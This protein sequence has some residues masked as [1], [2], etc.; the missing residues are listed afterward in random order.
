MDEL[1]VGL[2]IP[3]LRV[4]Y[5]RLRP[6][7]DVLS[8]TPPHAIGVAFTPQSAAVWDVGTSCR[9]RAAIPTSAVFITSSEPLL[10]ARRD[11]LRLDDVRPATARDH[12]VRLRVNGPERTVF[13]DVRSSLLDTR[14]AARMRSRPFRSR[15]ASFDLAVGSRVRQEGSAMRVRRE[16][17]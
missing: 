7:E 12:D 6:G 3:G 15:P 16:A 10:W 9:R 1:V 4:E 2:R 11:R 14:R 17:S 8:V 13:I 5:A